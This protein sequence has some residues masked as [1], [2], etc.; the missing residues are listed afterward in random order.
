MEVFYNWFMNLGSN[1]GVNPVI[2]GLI[3]VG[4]IPIFLIFMAWGIKNIKNKTSPLFPFFICI[5]CA[6][7]SYVYLILAGKNVSFW[8]YL[9]VSLMIL[10]SIYSV[11]NKIKSAKK[12][13]LNSEKIPESIYD[14]VVLGGG[15]AGLVCAGGAAVIGSKVLLVEKGKLGGDCLYTG[16]VPSKSLIRISRFKNELKWA[17]KFGF[18]PINAQFAENNFEKSSSYIQSIISDIEKKDSPDVFKKM[19]VEVIF[20]N[21]RFTGVDTLEIISE[22]GASKTIRSKNFCIATGSS[23]QIPALKGLSDAG[24]ITN[25]SIFNLKKLPK[26]LAVIGGGAIGLELGQALCRLDVKVF[27]F[28]SSERILIKEDHELSSFLAGQLE[29]EGIEIVSQA[30]VSEIKKTT[31]G[32]TILYN[33]GDKSTHQ[34]LEVEEILIATGR[35]INID[36]LNLDVAN[37]KYNK[38]QILTNKYLQTSNKNIYAAGDVTGRFQFTHMA[39][40]EAQH[41][42]HNAF[43]PW[44]F[45]KKVDYSV[46]PRT[47]FTDPEISHVGLTE[48]Q[49]AEKLGPKKYKVLK[50]NFNHN[51]KATADNNTNGFIK[52]I[53]A[54]NFKQTILGV[55]IIHSHASELLSEFSVAMKNGLNLNDINKAIHVY[56]T[57]SKITQALAIEQTIR[58]Y[59]GELVQ[60]ILQTYLKIWRIF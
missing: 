14:L 50:S 44:P 33:V 26:S 2:F 1:Y 55:S 42:V 16:C 60:K 3:Y 58:F 18:E 39:D 56:P 47:I 7:S 38:T 27:I 40:Y 9:I 23:P 35:T 41:V 51:D 19:G 54:K 29:N 10:Y 8:I 37:V 46:S 32:K 49:A 57:L 59:Q 21:P 36:G 28:D 53:I 6:I 15:S 48:L 45:R 31:G 4:T 25:E 17:E 20:A 12:S 52:I 34:K 5:I 11:I 30:R 43:T 24:Y 22:N 13:H